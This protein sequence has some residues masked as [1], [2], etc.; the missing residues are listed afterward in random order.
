MSSEEVL[1]VERPDGDKEVVLTAEFVIKVPANTDPATLAIA[2]KR[3]DI[4][5][6]A[7]TKTIEVVPST[8]VGY[9]TVDCAWRFA[10]EER[11]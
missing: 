7:K 9:T 11:K 3:G 1:A 5:V 4:S 10:P 8:L 6:L 2:I